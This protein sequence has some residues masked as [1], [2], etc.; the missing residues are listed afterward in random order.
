[1]NV[2]F[3]FSAPAYLNAK[4]VAVVG[5]FNGYNEHF[6]QMKRRGNDWGL[7][8]DLPPGEY[9]YKFLINRA[10]RLNDPSVN[11]V[12][13]LGGYGLWT[14]LFIDESGLRAFEGAPVR[15]EGCAFGASMDM[16]PI[17]KGFQANVD[18][19]VVVRLGFTGSLGAH[20][21]TALWYDPDG[22]LHSIT[23][24]TLNEDD[25]SSGQLCYLWF[26]MHLN[27]PRRE[28]PPGNWTVKVLVNGRDIFEDIFTLSNESAGV[29]R[30]CDILA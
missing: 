15:L 19:H 24:N 23:E 17:C 3:R 28:Y 1:M 27:N 14:P 6:G 4:E 12:I 22:K 9:Y 16:E 11:T 2:K 21:V 13:P 7:I 29:F 30:R 26:W 18:S 5:S 8:L 25:I 20:A 10:I